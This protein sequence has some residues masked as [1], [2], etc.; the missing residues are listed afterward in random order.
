MRIAGIKLV[1][2]ALGIEKIDAADAG[3]Y[4]RFGDQPQADSLAVIKLIQNEGRIYRMQGAHRLQFHL[5]L[6]DC[7]ARFLQIERLLELLTPEDK[8]N[9]S[10]AG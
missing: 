3:G 5:D 2:T 4:L 6:S 8:S 10:L 9:H 1:A 7:D